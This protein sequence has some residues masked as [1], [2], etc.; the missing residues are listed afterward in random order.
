MNADSNDDDPITPTSTASSK[1]G[2]LITPDGGDRAPGGE[3]WVREP[4]DSDVLCG[5]GGSINSHSGN[6]RFRQL[7][8]RRK[9]V[10]LTA[11]F[12]REKR[13][14]ASSIVSEIS[15]LNPPGRFLT[16][17]TK[18]GLWYPI[19]DEKARD[20]TSQALR[21]NAPSIRAEIETEIN[22]QRAEMQRAE[23]EEHAAMVTAPPPPHPYYQQGWGYYY[24]YY[25]YQQ[26][27]PPHP[28]GATPGYPPPSYGPQWNCETSQRTPSPSASVA[29]RR[30]GSVGHYNSSVYDKQ[31]SCPN[32]TPQEP[33]KSTFEQTANFVSSVPTTIAAWTKSS[34][35]FGAYSVNSADDAHHRDTP[36][37]HNKP[38]SYVHHP[39]PIPEHSSSDGLPDNH[40]RVVHFQDD[41]HH[42]HRRGHHDH[43]SYHSTHSHSQSSRHSYNRERMSYSPINSKN[44]IEDEKFHDLQPQSPHEGEEQSTSLLSQVANHILGSLGSWDTHVICAHD[45]SDDHVPFAP[46][47]RHSGGQLTSSK[48]AEVSREETMAIEAEGQEVQL[49]DMMEYDDCDVEDMMEPES[50]MPPPEEKPRVHIDWPSRV[51]SCHSWIPDTLTLGGASSLFSKGSNPLSPANSMEME[52]SAGGV[53]YSCGGES[54]GGGSLC[55]VFDKDVLTG[56]MGAEGMASPMS[57]LNHKMVLNQIPSWERSFLNKSPSSVDSG[58]EHLIERT[59]SGKISPIQ[60]PANPRH[61]I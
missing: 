12:K 59:S 40:R 16:K 39:E 28:P 2:M 60:A 61:R 17:D 23:E 42:S 52:T 22:Q 20:K 46:G 50:R 21:E 1:K 47:Q 18:T 51:G 57:N 55:H 7:V 14:I 26:P 38:I 3:C 5:R 9:R 11:R 37:I 27:P 35:S 30:G 24:P 54:V 4:T 25:G 10:Y 44:S 13:L 41:G 15:S 56:D 31:E 49:I 45:S 48:P 8:E 34:F 6:E 58:D 32:Y 36:T 29:S 43:H 19:G 33:S 53:E